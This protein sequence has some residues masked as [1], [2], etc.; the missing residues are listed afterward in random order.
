MLKYETMN[1]KV[2]KFRMKRRYK[3]IAMISAHAPTE[4][5]EEREKEEVHECLEEKNSVALSPRANYT[6]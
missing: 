2:C 3:D 4:G 1:D 6:D 5:K